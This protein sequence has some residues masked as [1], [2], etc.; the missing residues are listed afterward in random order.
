MIGK[1]ELSFP[2][3]PYAKQSITSSDIEAAASALKHPVI[4]RGE[5]V[6]EFERAVADYCEARY[7]VA[8]NSGTSALAAA[9]FAAEISA[10]DRVISTPN[11]FVATVGEAFR[12]GAQVHF[13]DID[14]KTGSM[15]LARLKEKLAYQATRGRTIIVPV[16]F[17][18]IAMDMQQ[19]D[20]LIRN[21]DTIVIEDAAHAFG[22]LYPDG[23]KV[24]SCAWS[25][26]TV[27]S[28]HPAK[29]IT[30]GE[31]GMVLTNDA[32][33]HHRLQLYRNNGIERDP[34]RLE[35]LPFP[36]YY[37]VQAVTGNFNFT[38]FQAALGLS[39]LK[40]LDDFITRRRR[41]MKVYREKL[42][43]LVHVKLLTSESDPQTAFH[44]CAVQVDF[45]ACNTTREK[46]MNRLKERGIGTQVHYIPVYQHPF[47]Q[48]LKG[49]ISEEFPEMGSYYQQALTLPLYYDLSE[50]DV[51]RICRELGYALR[52]RPS[53][54]LK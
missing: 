27:F 44:L 3:L 2:F 53:Y 24:G 14:R 22:S 7:A 48:K 11:T 42:K 18:G 23:Q 37:E 31:G 38:D 43:N 26:L 19:F 12:Q 20:Q 34:A 10:F 1:K 16:H 30:T 36:G 47:F 13:V 21:A 15:H 5:L 4:T 54:K 6:E 8:F 45:E 33:L 49:D 46:V 41:L 9:Y 52:T 39:Q 17:A 50:E 28:F 35:H 51:K 25:H 29:T 32:Y 40:R